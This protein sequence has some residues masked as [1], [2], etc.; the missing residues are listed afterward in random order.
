M[1]RRKPNRSDADREEWIL[2]DEGLYMWWKSSRMPMRRFVRE[3]RREIDEAID[4]AL[5]PPSQRR[6]NPTFFWQNPVASLGRRSNPQRL[7]NRRWSTKY[8]NDLP[9]S[10]F[11][12]VDED[13]V[14]YKDDKGR[15]HPLSCRKLPVKNHLGNY[16]CDHLR[17]AEA[18]AN[19]VK[20]VSQAER[21]RAKK[22]ASDLYDRYCRG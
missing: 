3:N 5:A 11:L 10:A 15:S 18:R 21:M 22:R 20:G 14:S 16:D 8:Q 4:R 13:C 17:N 7:P 1:A 6:Y 2:N 9:D 12:I 19:Q